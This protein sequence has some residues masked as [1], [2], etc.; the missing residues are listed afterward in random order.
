MIGD[1]SEATTGILDEIS[2]AHPWLVRGKAEVPFAIPTLDGPRHPEV[3]ARLWT[4]LRMPYIISLYG[5]ARNAQTKQPSSVHSRARRLGLVVPEPLPIEAPH[6][7]RFPGC[8]AVMLLV[9]PANRRIPWPMHIC[10]T[11]LPGRP[12]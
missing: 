6:R 4:D 2:G 7:L 10:G 1:C 3:G 8:M 11:F 12:R 5:H 9:I